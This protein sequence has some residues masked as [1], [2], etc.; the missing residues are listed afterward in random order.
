MLAGYNAGTQTATY[1]VTVNPLV[2]WIWF[3]FG[4]DGARH[5]HRAAAGGR[6]RVCRRQDARRRR[7]RDDV[8]PDP[9]LLLPHTAHAQHVDNPSDVPNI[10]VAR[11]PL[12]KELWGEIICTCGGCGR[13]RIG[14]FCCAKAAGMRAEVA[15]LL[16]AGKT[17]DE[18]YQYFIA[19]YGS[20]EPLAAPI[21]KGFNR[22]AWLFPYLVGATGAVAW[23]SWP[24]AGPPAVRP[25]VRPP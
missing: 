14:D 9:A 22:L 23:R 21:D 12:E 15:K 19:Q 16:D 4:G 1:A 8:A 25:T 24:C 18:V 17:R 13:K 5:A 20:Q 2:N 11:S 10:T 7:R 3:G 6:L